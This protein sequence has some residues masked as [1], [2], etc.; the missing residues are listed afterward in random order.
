MVEASRTLCLCISDL[1]PECGTNARVPAKGSPRLAHCSSHEPPLF[2]FYGHGNDTM[3][4]GQDRKPAIDL[5]NAHLLKG[6]VVYAMAC[7][8][9]NILGP[10]VINAGG[11]AY[12][13]FSRHFEFIPYTNRVFGQCVNNVAKEIMNGRCLGDALKLARGKFDYHI[14]KY[15]RK[16]NGTDG[17]ELRK[18]FRKTYELL[19]HDKSCLTLLGDPKITLKSYKV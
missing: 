1:C 5:G 4:I 18:T 13:G 11:L 16:Y 2:I 10:A 15:K 6:W 9:A 8:T 19:I 17:T 14:K 12:I 7:N 3:M